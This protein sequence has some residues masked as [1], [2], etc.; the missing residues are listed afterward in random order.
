LL[1]IYFGLPYLSFGEKTENILGIALLVAAKSFAIRLM[2]TSI[3]SL[4][5]GKFY[6]FA[7]KNGKLKNKNSAR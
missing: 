4:P 5:G 1:S 3:I 7:G 6:P 2:I